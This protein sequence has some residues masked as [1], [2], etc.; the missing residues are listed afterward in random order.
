[1]KRILSFILSMVLVI[2]VFMVSESDVNAK[3]VKKSGYY[4][5][6]LQGKKSKYGD[7]I[8]IKKFK[9]KGNKIITYG[10]FEYGK[11]EPTGKIIKFRKRTF[12]LSKKCKYM[13]GWGVPYGKKKISKKEAMRLLKVYYQP[14]DMSATCCIFKVKKGKVVK[15]MMGQA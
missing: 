15:F 2:S 7:N 9:I 5:T 12:V 4:Y 13:D 8:Y 1:M 3:T 6:V 14:G 11:S 10:N